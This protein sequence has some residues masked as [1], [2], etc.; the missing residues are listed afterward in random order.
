MTSDLGGGP[1][2]WRI[3]NPR[4]LIG[5]AFEAET[6]VDEGVHVLE[7]LREVL[8]REPDFG[9]IIDVHTRRAVATR[10]DVRMIWTFDPILRWV[11]VV[12]PP[13]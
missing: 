1:R 4:P 13:C 10:T 2:S 7:F 12:V 3:R 11:E 6:D 9:E 8:C 5:W